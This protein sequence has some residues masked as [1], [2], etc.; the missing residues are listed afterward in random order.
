MSPSK[1]AT[2]LRRFRR[3]EELSADGYIETVPRRG[4]RFAARIR[5]PD[6][7]SYMA[8]P[9]KRTVRFWIACA[10]AL[11]AVTIV[12]WRLPSLRNNPV[13]AAWKTEPLTTLEGAE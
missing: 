13:E 8:K 5:E 2:C 1:R 11:A 6:A 7:E 9:A 12:A 4:Y 10:I 3:F